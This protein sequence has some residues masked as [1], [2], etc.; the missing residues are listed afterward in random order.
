MKWYKKLLLAVLIIRGAIACF[1]GVRD[2]GAIGAFVLPICF[3]GFTYLLWKWARGDLPQI[4]TFLM[5]LIALIYGIFVIAITD[6]L[7]SIDLNVDT[8]EVFRLQVLHQP[9]VMLVMFL[10]SLVSVYIW[11]WLFKEVRQQRECLH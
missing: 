3:I 9:F 5:A 11:K 1:T 10:G 4:S 7:M 8:G 6:Y 2:T